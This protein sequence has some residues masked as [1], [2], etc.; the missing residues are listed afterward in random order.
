MPRPDLRSDQRGDVQSVTAA[1]APG[2][3]A[4]GAG[5]FPRDDAKTLAT[6]HALLER[7]DATFGQYNPRKYVMNEK[8]MFAWRDGI[9]LARELCD[10][11]VGNERADH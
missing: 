10:K 3:F 4:P 11:L 1:S 6:L 9:H 7:L 5:P 8:H 2:V